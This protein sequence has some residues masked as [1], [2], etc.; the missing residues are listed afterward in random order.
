MFQPGVRPLEKVKKRGKSQC[1]LLLA[2]SCAYEQAALLYVIIN[3]AVCL[4]GLLNMT[5]QADGRAHVALHQEFGESCVMHVMAGRTL[6]LAVQEQSAN[7]GIG[8][9]NQLGVTVGDGAGIGEGYRVVVGQVGA[10]QRVTGSD[11]G[12]ARNLMVAVNG[13]RAVMA[14]ETC[15]GSAVRQGARSRQVGGVDGAEM[16][17][18][19]GE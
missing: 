11:F 13:N 17:N 8:S 15:L 16:I 3:Y 5:G 19:G 14:G 10:Q 1:A 12:C 7:V 9:A 18:V 4:L 6:N 2:S